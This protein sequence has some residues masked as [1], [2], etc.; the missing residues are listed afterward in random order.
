M[1]ICKKGINDLKTWCSQHGNFGQQL[2]TEWTED[3]PMD[4]IAR[5]SGKKVK[6]RC[7]KGHEWYVSINE[8]TGKKRSCP[9]CFR[10]NAS[11]LMT[12]AS[13]S[14]E[15]SLKTWCMQNGAF[16][17][18]LISEWTGKLYDG[19]KTNLDEVT[20]A[21]GKRVKWR[22]DKGHE[23]YAT[24]YSRTRQK[25]GC[26]YCSGRMASEENSL[27]TWCMQNGD[28]GKQLMSEWTGELEDGAETSLDEVAKASRKRVRWRCDKGHEWY[29]AIWQRTSQ[30]T[31]CPYCY[32]K[33]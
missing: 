24:I 2:M 20:R 11:T 7:S 5:G 13:L 1:R 30:K 3:I 17:Q 21:S 9:Y 23:W 10:E 4:S 18:Q 16:G 25:C 19:T 15:N 33:N 31:E 28:F 29:T 12:K 8:R 26:P 22:C 27:K 32:R 6:W 14:E